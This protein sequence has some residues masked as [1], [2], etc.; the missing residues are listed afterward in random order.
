[1][2]NVYPLQLFLCRNVIVARI[3]FPVFIS[4]GMMMSCQ[5]HFCIYV[6]Y[7]EAIILNEKAE[8][9]LIDQLSEDKNAGRRK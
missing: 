9:L 2:C 4:F 7:Q 1:M 6:V 8:C 5:V 3:G